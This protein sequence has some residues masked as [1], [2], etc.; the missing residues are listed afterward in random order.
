MIIMIANQ[1]IELRC[2]RTGSTGIY[3][4]DSNMYNVPLNC[5]ALMGDSRLCK[6]V[7]IGGRC[8]KPAEGK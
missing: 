5:P 6:L 3:R 4:S 1:V 8:A 2:K 7:V